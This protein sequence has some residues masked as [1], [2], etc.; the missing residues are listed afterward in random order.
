MA[1][2]ARRV[3]SRQAQLGR[4]R[5]RQQKGPSGVPIAEPAPTNAD[6]GQSTAADLQAPKPAAPVAEPTPAPAPVAPSPT[7]PRPV[8]RTSPPAFARVRGERPPADKYIGAEL[9][10]I[11]VMAGSVLAAIIVLGIIL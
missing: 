11:L 7:A 2:K 9:K 3:A 4:R 6:G 10:R 1:G 5:K 8:A